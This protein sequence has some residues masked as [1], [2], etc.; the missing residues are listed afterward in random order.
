MAIT[1]YCS[2]EDVTNRVSAAGADARVD[3]DP[4]VQADVLESA[5]IEV[6]GYLQLRYSVEDLATSNWV[7]FKTRDVAVYLLFLRRGHPPTQSATLLYDKAIADLEKVAAGTT[8]VADIA[9]NK[10]AVPVLSNQRVTLI[11]FPR[12]QTVQGKSTG[13]PESYPQHVDQH[14]QLDYAG[15]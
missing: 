12:V 8:R 7:R 2:W 6:N 1:T 10:A 9:E 15:P 13:T 14:D 11:P 3:D 4:S 5:A